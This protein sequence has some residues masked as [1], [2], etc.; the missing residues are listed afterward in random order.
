MIAALVTMLGG[1]AIA[2]PLHGFVKLLPAIRALYNQPL[3]PGWGLW[4]MV[5]A[6]SVLILLIWRLPGVQAGK[7]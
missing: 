5:I 2:A 7:Q 6:L 4:L 1:V 3:A